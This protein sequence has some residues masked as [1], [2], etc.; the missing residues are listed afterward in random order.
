MKKNLLLLF[1]GIWMLHAYGKQEPKKDYPIRPVNFTQVKVDDDFWSRRIRLNQSVTIPI[2]ID[3]CYKT[4]R[5][6]NF[7]IA[8]KLAK[9][10]FQSEY[11]FDDS[12]LYKIIEG[13]SYSLQ[14][15]PDPQLEARM[16][17]LIRY[18]ALAQEPDGYLYTNRTIDSLHL[19]PWVGKKRW[20]KDPEL[21]HELYNLG[22]LY[23]AAYAHFLATG[24][25]S[26]L[27][28]A[29]KSANL[30]DHDFGPG[31]LTYYPGHQVIEM[32]LA[33][34][35]RITGEVRYLN[36]ARFF[37]D[38]R[39]NG[40]E[41]NQAHLPVIEQTQIVGHAV[42]ATY[43]YAGMADVS[44]LTGEISYRLAIDK[45]WSDLIGTKFYLTGGIGSAG[46]NE[47]FSD[48][49]NLPN[50]T[51]YCETC[52][53]I[54]D[55][56]WNY[57]MFLLEGEG[58]YY[59]IL[60]R[61]LYNALLSGISLSADHFFYPNPL[62]SHGEH[63]RSAWFGCACCP[64]NICRF[65]PSIPGYIYAQ[66]GDSL[67]VNLFVQNKVTLKSKNGTI[68]LEQTTGYPW[69]G[70]VVLKVSSL[71]QPGLMSLLVRIPG[72]ARN[73]AVPSQLYQFKEEVKDR[74]VLLVN[75]KKYPY[76]INKGYAEVRRSWRAGDQLAIHFP[77]PVREIKA[78]PAVADDRGKIALQRGPVVYCA[79]WP[80]NKEINIREL[81]LPAKLHFSSD[82]HAD[83]L[84]GVTVIQTALPS[85]G[86]DAKPVQLTAI[87][88]Y[89]WAN[90][91]QGEMSVWLKQSDK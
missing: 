88:Y 79:E 29:L 65:I 21:S 47:G 7:R 41:Y 5:V 69:S 77:M 76:R 61:T 55:V 49:Y 33:K 10:K 38:C 70:E 67:Y 48:P 87:P 4:G 57:R 39:K 28:V 66:K 16:D 54:S 19:H 8:A 80:D 52:A 51:A 37:L 3:Q 53:S 11:P 1:W 12:D 84:N 44:A 85:A 72:W 34:L 30:V 90:R 64:S 35:Y 81:I 14:T 32:G 22:H 91:G 83:L 59:D 46:T 50:H 13:A 6:E 71:P 45:I 89:A 73:E 58:K 15:H 20:E 2:A 17:T 78:N 62:E 75:G 9:G 74:T 82:F 63:K 26:L 18:I 31:K 68:G 36:L 43:M 56:F 60:E 86:P 27:D 23:E 25:R 42:R 24:K 40:S